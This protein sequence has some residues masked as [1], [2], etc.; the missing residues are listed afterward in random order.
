MR[1]TVTTL[2]VLGLAACA[3]AQ[4]DVSFA[5]S[6]GPFSREAAARMSEVWPE[7]RQA[8]EYADINWRAIGLDEAP[9][10][11]RA[12]RVLAANWDSLRQA[13]DFRD[14]D[15]ESST[16][17]DASE[18]RFRTEDAGP[19]G[20]RNEASFDDSSYAGPFTRREAEVLA[21]VWPQIRQAG[22][23]QDIDW[24][25]V[26]VDYAPGDARARSGEELGLAATGIRLP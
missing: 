7:V 11:A 13:S 5:D 17:Y 4:E 6:S 8:D 18:D 25:A 9:G 23:Y 10:D 1:A 21:D 12:Q 24:E 14:I 19:F 20:R 26:G 3:V 15:W 2:A 16:G 22:S